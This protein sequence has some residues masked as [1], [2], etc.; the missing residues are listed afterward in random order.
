MG[1]VHLS[2][3]RRDRDL[4]GVRLL[5]GADIDIGAVDG[6]IHIETPTMELIGRESRGAYLDLGNVSHGPH[7]LRG[8]SAHGPDLI[9]RYKIQDFSSRPGL[10]ACSAVPC[11]TVQCGEV[12]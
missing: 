8:F 7:P 11:D 6:N 1:Q 2:G 3:N 5:D 10:E 4:V 12:S 9:S